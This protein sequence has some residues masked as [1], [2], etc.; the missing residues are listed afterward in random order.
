MDGTWRVAAVTGMENYL[1]A[2]GVT[3]EQAKQLIADTAG[4]YFT[5]ERLPGGKMR[6]QTNSKWLPA[7]LVIKIGETYSFDVPGFG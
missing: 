3:G 2:C 4:E 7:E 1:A 6:S 5:I